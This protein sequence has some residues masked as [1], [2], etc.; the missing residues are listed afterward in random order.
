MS[1]RYTVEFSARV[2]RQMQERLPEA[3]VAAVLEFAKGPL[4]ENPFRVGKRLTPPLA[5]QH[6]AR[7]GTYRIL[8]E[9]DEESQTVAVINVVHRRDAYRSL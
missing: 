4:S 5:S 8:Y 9:I 7:R 1:A 6:S 3:V 2:R